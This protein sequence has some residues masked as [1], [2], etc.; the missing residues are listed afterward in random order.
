MNRLRVTLVYAGLAVLLAAAPAAASSPF[1]TIATGLLNPRGLALGPNGRL[2]VAEAGVGAGT[3]SVEIGPTGRVIAI[4]RPGKAHPWIHTIRTGITSI[5]N[6][7]GQATE[8]VGG[9]SVDSN[10]II[11]AIVGRSAKLAGS[12]DPQIGQLLRIQQNGAWTAAGN[13]GDRGYYFTKY[14]PGLDPGGQFPDSNPYGVLA[15]GHRYVV[16]A[17]ANTLDVVKADGTVRVLAWFPNTQASDAVPTCVARGPDGALYIGT[18]AL[19][20]SLFAGP[21]HP[22]ATVYRVDLSQ[23]NP[24]NFTAITSVATVWAKGFWPIHG[25]T[26]GPDGSFWVS[27]IYTKVGPG[28]PGGGAIVRVPWHHPKDK[29]LRTTY[30]VGRL[31]A[32]GGIAVAGDGTVYVVNRTTSTDGEVLRFHP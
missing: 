8:G 11:W 9:I 14:H 30:G 3:D 12:S 5:G 7:S 29:S 24:N 17:G 13:V 31:D 15:D 21:P 27:E 23:T 20:D 18:L 6:Q 2:Y 32:A 16:D 22:A 25:C 10:G 4:V 26:F 19:V 28:G 1:H